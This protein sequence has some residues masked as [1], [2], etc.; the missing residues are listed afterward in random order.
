MKITIYETVREYV[1]VEIE[2][3]LEGAALEEAIEEARCSGEGKRGLIDVTEI[4]WEVTE[5]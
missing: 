2:D 3:G 1:D 4:S 5:E